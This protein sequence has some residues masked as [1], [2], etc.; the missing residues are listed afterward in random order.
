LQRF[1]KVWP[2]WLRR[3]PERVD[4]VP[5]GAQTGAPVLPIQIERVIG[6]IAPP[7]L[8]RL[9]VVIVSLK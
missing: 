6:E 9:R 5:L 7:V 3:G 4:R 2:K 1:A 8:R